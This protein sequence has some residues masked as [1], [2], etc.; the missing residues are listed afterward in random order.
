VTLRIPAG[1][2]RDAWVSADVGGAVVDGLLDPPDVDVFAARPFLVGGAFV[3]MPGVA[4]TVLGRRAG[5]LTIA[6]PL[7]HVRAPAGQTR[8]ERPCADFSP[9]PIRYDPLDAVP[10]ADPIGTA[11]VRAGAVIDLAPRRG[12]PA[13]I[14]IAA[15]P[16]AEV[17]DVLGRDGGER[18]IAYWADASVVVGWVAAAKLVPG[19][20][21]AREPALET[22]ASGVGKHR[23]GGVVACPGDVDLIAEVGGER[24]RVGV[25]RHGTPID[26]GA[27]RDAY[28][29][30]E[31]PFTEMT[32]A[33]DA[34]LLVPRTAV[35]SCPATAS[36]TPRLR[37]P[38][39]G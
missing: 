13:T 1:T 17:V 39:G 31:L 16:R 38:D 4:L 6:A 8:S 20:L 22:P 37:D 33:L 25:V 11:W 21:V 23:L 3:P 34:A 9:T 35:A 27:P 2:A 28:A 10:G 26:V 12:E 30:V 7:E 29:E 15:S 18:K 32:T 14:S 19:P 24:R 36:A 5:A